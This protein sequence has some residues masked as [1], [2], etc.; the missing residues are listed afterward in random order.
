MNGFFW[1]IRAFFK[2]IYMIHT[3][4]YACKYLWRSLCLSRKVLCSFYSCFH[5]IT[6]SYT[7]ILQML[8]EFALYQSLVVEEF[9]VRVWDQCQPSIM[10][11]L[12]SNWF[13]M[14]I[15]VKKASNGWSKCQVNV[16]PAVNW[17]A[18]PIN[19]LLC[20]E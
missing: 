1:L 10:R 20:L 12:G 18:L 8:R 14:V 13:V 11:N 3:F 9:S 4:I 15:P 5:D 7:Y 19:G 6:N 16:R 2:S 17:Q